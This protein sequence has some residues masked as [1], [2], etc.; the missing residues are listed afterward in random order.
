VRAGGYTL[1]LLGAPRT[2]L[3]LRSLDDEPKNGLELRRSSGFPAPSTLRGHLAALE[4]EGVIHHRRQ[5][6]S[7]RTHE[8]ELTE[9][10]RE[11]LTVAAGL[12]RWLG[13]APDGPLELG[14]HAAKA[15]VHGLVTGWATTVLT[16]L[17]AAPLSLTELDKRISTVSYPTIERCLEA[18]R[19]AR[20][21]ETG[22]RTA[23]GT[24]HSLDAWLHRGVAPLVLAA[25]WEHCHRPAGAEPIRLADVADACQ[26]ISPLLELPASRSGIC[27]LALR[28]A[29]GDRRKR[30]LNSIELREGRL[31]FGPVDRDRKPDAW[32]SATADGWF[33]VVV[34]GDARG[35]RLSG[36]RRLA[37]SSWES[38]HE[39]IVALVPAHI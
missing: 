6:S 16:E 30:V 8:Y 9:A 12:E 10:G 37:T 22:P 3:I 21:L 25:R 19:L 24:P 18:M 2:S 23:T 5:D 15:A 1:A 36:D 4:T 39:A 32:M 17:A 27:Q 26:L 35:L 33:A 29:D 11:L 38:L 34:D 20:Q 7:A 14:N 13:E 31:T 28:P